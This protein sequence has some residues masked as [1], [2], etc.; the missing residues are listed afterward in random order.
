MFLSH[1]HSTVKSPS[2]THSH[3]FLRTKIL[4]FLSQLPFL[5][6]LRKKGSSFNW[7]SKV[8]FFFAGSRLFMQISYFDFAGNS[9]IRVFF[10]SI[11]LHSFD[12]FV[13]YSYWPYTNEIVIGNVAEMQWANLWCQS[14]IRESPKNPAK[15]PKIIVSTTVVDGFDFGRHMLIS[16]RL[17]QLY[18]RAKLVQP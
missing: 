5:I 8:V 16:N 11:S 2:S 9:S 3:S 6:K 12:S 13:L 15:F 14:K 10:L 7:Q 4:F 17:P 18:Y 1:F